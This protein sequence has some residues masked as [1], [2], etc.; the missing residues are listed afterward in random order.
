MELNKRPFGAGIQYIRQPGAERQ[1]QRPPLP[2]V[3]VDSD[4]CTGCGVCQ[5]MCGVDA[6]EIEDVAQIDAERCFLCGACVQGCPEGALT[7]SPPAR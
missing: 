5:A 2:Q 7:W 1:R 4:A 6:I 3:L